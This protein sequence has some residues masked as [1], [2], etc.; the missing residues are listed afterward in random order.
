M[1]YLIIL[2]EEKGLTP[3]KLAELSG[4]NVGNIRR[5]MTLD[6]LE[7]AYK[8]TTERLAK[9]LG[10]TPKELIEGGTRMKKKILETEIRKNAEALALALRKFADEPMYLR[11]CVFTLDNVADDSSSAPDYYDVVCHKCDDLDAN[12]PV[13]SKA[14]LIYYGEEGVE[15]TE[16]FWQRA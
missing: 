9:A 7:F 11:L 15:K 1:N 6:T 14:F 2:M 4:C 8:K 12:E 10:V 5:L 13:M 3:K 16:E